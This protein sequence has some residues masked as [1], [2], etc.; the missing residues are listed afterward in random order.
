[1]FCLELQTDSD[2]FDNRHFQFPRVSMLMFHTEILLHVSLIFIKCGKLFEVTVSQK[3]N[4]LLIF[5]FIP[6]T[7]N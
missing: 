7:I 2:Y 1:M 4:K 5:E 3:T 6:N